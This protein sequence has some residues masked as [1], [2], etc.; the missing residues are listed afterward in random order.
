MLSA[1]STLNAPALLGAEQLLIFLGRMR[2]LHLVAEGL[3]G[4]SPAVILPGCS[5]YSEHHKEGAL[6]TVS[7]VSSVA[8]CAC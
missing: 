6:K 7:A 1:Q 3:S 4:H 5:G 8:G 2:A